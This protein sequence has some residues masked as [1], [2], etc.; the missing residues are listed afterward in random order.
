[1][2]RLLLEM[3]FTRSVFKDQ[4]EHKL[5]GALIHFYQIKYARANSKQKWVNHWS[6]ELKRL[7]DEFQALLLHSIKGNWNRT[8]AAR[9]VVT[10][11]N[12]S[13]RYRVAAYNTVC[14]DFK[15]KLPKNLPDQ[16]AAKFWTKV[17]NIISDIG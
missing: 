1:M 13:D 9:E 16:S 10:A 5:T 3:A 17:D 7:L 12:N 14:R 11:M 4:L 15:Q 6:T 2:M 8:R